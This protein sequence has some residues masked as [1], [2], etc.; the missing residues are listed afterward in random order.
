MAEDSIAERA[1]RFAR[2]AQTS[3]SSVTI[4]FLEVPV[5]ISALFH[6]HGPPG[7]DLARLMFEV[8]ERLGFECAECGALDTGWI[9]REYQP[10]YTEDKALC[11]SC[12][13]SDRVVLSYDPEKRVESPF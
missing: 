4:P 6:V 13:G 11:P 7:P 9:M 2:E 1:E 3:P 12:R 5:F 8:P 10:P